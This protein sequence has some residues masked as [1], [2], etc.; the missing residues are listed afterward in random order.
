[1]DMFV[2]WQA[3]WAALL[4]TILIGCT[5]SPEPELSILYTPAAQYHGPDRNPIIVIPGVLGS[6]LRDAS[7]RLAWGAF[8]GLAADPSDPEG[9]RLI[10]LPIE[11]E[12]TLATLRD[13]VV[14]DGVLERVRVRLLGIPI[15][16]EAYGAILS[17]LGA[18]GYRDESLGLA[19]EVDYG[20]DHFTCFQFDY[21][22]RRDNV[23]NAQRL[24]QFI[25]EKRAYVQ[26]E[27]LERFG[28]EKSDIK[29]DIVAHSMGGLITRY[30]LRY[31]SQDLNSDGSLPEIT[32]EGAEYVDRAILIATPNGGSVDA[33]LQLVNG[34]DIGRPFLPYYAPS[35]IGTFPSI[36]QLLPRSRHH[37]VVWAD[38]AEEPIEDI[39]DPALWERMGWGLASS[40]ESNMLATLMPD[41][42]DP[43]ERRQHALNLQAKI[44]RRADAFQ[45]ALDRPAV[46]PQHTQ[47][48]LVV[49]DAEETAAR[50]S[51]NAST[52]AL[53]IIGHDAGDGRVL[54]ESV[55]LDERADGR[56]QP[57]VR[58]P[59]RYQRVL[60][61]PED[62]L[63]LT[64][65]MT[66]RDNILYWLL[67]EPRA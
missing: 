37:R 44:L 13:D 30:F 65:S 31:G 57:E 3:V 49:G 61:L 16:L 33:F 52:G 45:R 41:I 54:R 60:L 63:G 14:A 59:L 51:V 62:H 38:G 53:S 27:Y 26:Q 8:D 17:T 23:E 43:V 50:V 58:T 35:L 24:H 32:W 28:I 10:A 7:G 66:F 36:Y 20:R 67:E 2:K 64:K 29:F 19:G 1:M 55:L 6:R 25:L 5:N 39:L 12:G 48:F 46:P 11:G 4:C 40:A 56:W 47:I 9:A 42:D 21:D 34:K 22:W 18:G 15:E